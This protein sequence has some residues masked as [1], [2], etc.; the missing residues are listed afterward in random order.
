MRH[1]LEYTISQEQSAF[2]PGR[3]I[4]D[5]ALVAFECVHAMKGKKKGKK[6]HYAVKLD[7]MKAYDR[8]EWPFVEA[9][10]SKLG[11]PS[12]LVQIIMKCVY[13]QSDFQLK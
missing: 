9:I 11:F 4:S 6:D 7:M 2:V 13:L 10:L 8:V 5:N 1:V 12:R 3:L